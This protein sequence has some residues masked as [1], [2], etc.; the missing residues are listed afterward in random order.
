MKTYLIPATALLLSLVSCTEDVMDRINEN[1]G[2]P[3]IDIVYGKFEITDAM[4]NTGAT[5]A[6]G[7]YAFYTSVYNEQIFG[8]GGNQLRNAELRQVSET[9]GSSTFNNVWNGTYGNLNTLKD[10]IA[11]CAP[12]GID[13]DQPDLLG[14]AQLLSAHNWEVLT[15]LHG[16]IPC[17]E[18]LQGQ[19][20]LQPKLDKQEDVYKHILTLVDDAIANFGKAIDEGA[21]NVGS[22]D[23]IYGNDN[24][25]WLAACYALRARVNLHLMVRDADAADRALADA[26]KA[27]ELGFSGFDLDCYNEETTFNPWA[28]FQESRL[29]AYNSAT[30]RDILAERNDPRLDLYISYL[31]INDPTGEFAT[32]CGT[33]GNERDANTTGA[34]GCPIWL[35]EYYPY[36][37]AWFTAAK[38]HIISAAEP[39]F[40]IAEMQAR[41]GL[42]PTDALASAVALAFDDIAYFDEIPGDAAT[43]M[44]EL[45][46]RI[47]ADPLKEVLTQKYIAQGRDE[48]VE[49]YNDIRR[50]KA[51]GRE[52]ITLTNPLNTTSGGQ[53][54]WPLRLPYGNSDVSSNT[55]VRA[56]YGDGMYVFTEPVWIFGGSR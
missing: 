54:R 24:A 53:N 40:I 9:A 39:L 6:S 11:K 28:S 10:I 17:S 48:Q 49:T 42:D 19:G 14:M 36:P 5:V 27:V 12:D 7:D 43:Y 4:A 56:A 46:D 3:P 15:A 47:A 45:V 29:Y 26:E 13:H 34:L 50:C 18:A 31:Y 37:I 33:P 41:K 2:N 22:Q 16:D 55:N 23:I 52:L 1:K 35:L 8:G 25:A 21:S 38:S 20:N 32:T 30:M 51:L 44:A